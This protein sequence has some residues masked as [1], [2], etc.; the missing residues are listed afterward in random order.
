M[1]GEP[2][3]GRAGDAGVLAGAADGPNGAR[4]ARSGKIKVH[5]ASKSNVSLYVVLSAFV[6][7]TVFAL[8]TMDYGKVSFPAAM[9]AAVED[10]VTMMTQPGLGGHFTLPDVIEG[11]FVSLALA[12]LTTFIGAVIAFVLGLL[13][14]CN[15]SNKGVSNVIKVFMSVARA[16]PTILWV[17]VFSVAIGLGPEAAVVGLLFHSVA[18]LVK[19]Y[20]ESFEEVDAGVLEA[21]RARR[22]RA[23][24][25]S[26]ARRLPRRVACAWATRWAWALCWVAIS[27]VRTNWPWWMRRS[28][29]WTAPHGPPAGIPS[30]ARN[31]RASRRETSARRVASRRRRWISRRW[32]W[33]CDDCRGRGLASHAARVSGRP[34]CVCPSGHGA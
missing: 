8:V 28:P 14:S 34:R 18:Y 15:L 5:V 3:G 32:R 13:A 20:S 26:W 22:R 21:L 2:S 29:A 7:V 12:L 33:S 6:L 23:A 24:C 10:F 31:W 16:V 9:A 30:C 11:L 1:T 19:A 17:L 25:S 27:A 4:M